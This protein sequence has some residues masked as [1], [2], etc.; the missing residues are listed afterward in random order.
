MTTFSIYVYGKPWAQ[1]G[2][3]ML[4][5]LSTEAKATAIV[6]TAM[7]NDDRIEKCEVWACEDFEH[8]DRVFTKLR[9][10]AA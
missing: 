3:L 8:T 4:D 7:K 6:R 5:G 10:K 2:T 1:H 9:E